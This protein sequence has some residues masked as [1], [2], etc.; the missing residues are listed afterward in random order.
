MKTLKTCY[1]LSELANI[2][3]SELIGDP[4]YLIYGIDN[5][6]DATGK[7]ASFL[8]NP[9]YAKVFKTSKAGVVFLNEPLPDSVTNQLIH[10]SPSD[11]FQQII[12]LFHSNETFQSGFKDIHPSAVIHPTA[13]ISNGVSIGPNT[14][15]DQHAKIGSN[16][17]I[18]AN[19]TIGPH[20][21]IGENCLIHPQVVI[22]EN[23]LIGNYV[24]LQ[25]NAVIGSCG[26]GYRTTPQGNHEKIP[27]IG[28]VVLEDYVEIGASTC[29]DKARFKETL[30]KSGT[31]I[32]NLVQIAH[33]VHIGENSLIVAQVG[34]AGSTT[35]GKYNVIAGQV[36]IVGH[37]HLADHVVVAAKG[38]VSKSI[39]NPGRYAGHPAIPARA[40]Y[41]QQMHNRKLDTYITKM[42][43]LEAQIEELKKLLNPV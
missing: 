21:T 37:I 38:G 31:K 23:S 39:L 40:Y 9:L 18:H 32:D 1:T 35:L 19:V 30:I 29:I 24:I 3:S 2:T 16:T 12:N 13:E 36:G 15:I 5:L 4:E 7:D 8:A 34:I 43:D 20:V 22:R 26:Y 10:P 42:K 33:G 28:R 11:A 17:Q 27:H 41:K 14:T 25:P 6:K